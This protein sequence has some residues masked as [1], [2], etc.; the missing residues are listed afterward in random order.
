MYL[1]N[2]DG[3]KSDEELGDQDEIDLEFRVRRNQC[4]CQPMQ[5][6]HASHSNNTKSSPQGS[7]PRTLQTNVFLNGQEDLKVVDLAY[8]SSNE[9]HVY[10]VEWDDRT[11][12]FFADRNP[13]PIRTVQLARPL[14]PMNLHLSAWTTS[15]GWPG[16]LRWGGETNWAKNH[17][18]QDPIEAIFKVTHLPQIAS[19]HTA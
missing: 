10:A 9:V 14:K 6:P 18:G 19:T 1:T 17:P 13:E 16:L 15:K 8:D 7:H 12:R 11:V 3:R 5:T 2:G 4:Q